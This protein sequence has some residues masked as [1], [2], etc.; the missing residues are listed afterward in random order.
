MEAFLRM[1]QLNP[2]VIPNLQILEWAEWFCPYKFQ[3]KNLKGKYNVMT[4]NV[5][6]NLNNQFCVIRP[7]KHYSSLLDL[8]A[9]SE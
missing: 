5:I 2:K 8:S 9:Q 3:V 1:I 7:Q 6:F 4:Q